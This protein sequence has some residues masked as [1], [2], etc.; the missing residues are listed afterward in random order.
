MA[1]NFEDLLKNSNSTPP[2]KDTRKTTTLNESLT[3]DEIR[4]VNKISVTIPDTQTPI[5][6][7]FGSPASGKTLVLLRMI[8][9]LETH[10][11]QVVP[12]EIF[13]PKTD[14]HYIRMCAELKD[15]A[16]REYTPGATDIISFM[17][18]KV[19]NEV[20]KPVC[21]ILE[22]PGEHYFDGLAQTNFPRYIN[23]IRLSP[24]RKVWVFFVEQDWGN[25]Q[26]IRNLYAQKICSMQSLLSP[27]DRVVFLFNKAD[28][29]R[30]QYKPN[31]E[32]NKEIFF[33]NIRNQYPGIF[34]RYQ[35]SGITKVLYGPYN[36]KVVCF[37]AGEFNLTGDGQEAWTPGEDRYCQELWR[38]IR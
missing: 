38:A 13:R 36:F 30:E 19:L 26:G 34:S 6:I 9:F 7:F 31:G 35:N 16:Y 14:K 29:H 3:D 21:Q 33:A 18:V 24:N 17:L 23:A 22:A 32:P 27:Q 2:N 1:D 11:F 20:G 5:V 8:R 37:T 28:K 4:D 12:E 10:H 25:N 15:L